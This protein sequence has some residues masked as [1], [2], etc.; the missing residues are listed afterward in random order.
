MD[1]ESDSD[2]TVRLGKH[3]IV[4]SPVLIRVTESLCLMVVYYQVLPTTPINQEEK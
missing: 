4:F 1:E 2:Q 3:K